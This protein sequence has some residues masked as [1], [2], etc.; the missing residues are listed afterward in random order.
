MKNLGASSR[1]L[2]GPSFTFLE[3]GGGGGNYI[4]LMH[5]YVVEHEWQMGL[6]KAVTYYVTSITNRRV[7][8]YIDYYWRNVQSCYSEHSL[9]WNHG[10][11]TMEVHQNNQ[12]QVYDGVFIGGIVMYYNRITIRQDLMN[13]YFC[14]RNR[15]VNSILR[16]IPPLYMSGQY[17]ITREPNQKNKQRSIYPLAS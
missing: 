8:N 10:V 9:S 4:E 5:G 12:Y 16:N 3:L 11:M 15:I 2:A 17:I 1:T 6:S 13:L 7:S 14:H